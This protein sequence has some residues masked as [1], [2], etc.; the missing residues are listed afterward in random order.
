MNQYGFFN[1]RKDYRIFKDMGC[2]VVAEIGV[3]SGKNSER[4][5]KEIAP[6]EFHAIDPWLSQDKKVYNDGNNKKQSEQDRRM[7][8]AKKRIRNASNEVYCESYIHRGLSEDI[9]PRFDD[10]YFDLIY[11]DG[12]H[13]YE[14][15]LRDLENAFDKIKY[16]GFICGHDFVPDR[17]HGRFPS[18]YEAVRDFMKKHEGWNLIFSHWDNYIIAPYETS[19][20]LYN[21]ITGS[22]KELQYANWNLL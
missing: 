6:I 2:K 7:E 13:G 22:I 21:N 16:T 10:N 5:I 8:E 15:V 3:L 4:M 14:F 11:I 9:L 1:I 12:N 20:R 17:H 19:Q 18:V